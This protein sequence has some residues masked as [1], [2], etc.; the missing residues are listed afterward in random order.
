MMWARV[1]GSLVSRSARV[2]VGMFVA[3]TMVLSG[4]IAGAAEPACTTA[5]AHLVFQQG[6]RGFLLLFQGETD[7]R[8][9]D[10]V[11]RCQYR[12]FLHGQTFTFRENDVFLG[13]N[14][15][16]KAESELEAL[17]WTRR[18]AV[19][20][21]ESIETRVWLAP[22]LPDGSIGERVEQELRQTPVK[23]LP[24]T[25]S[26]KVFATHVAFTAQ[27]AAGDYVSFYHHK[28]PDLEFET[29]VHLHIVPADG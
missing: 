19:A 18:Q 8:I 14:F 17:G 25:P 5:D 28:A 12:L 7:R 26:G 6:E 10:L 27:L 29:M 9:A 13:G 11:R 21:L 16:F 1:R 15:L 23:T 24:K 3:A 2:A 20:Y 4:T 22:V